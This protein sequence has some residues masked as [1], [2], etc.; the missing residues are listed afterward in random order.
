MRIMRRACHKA[1]RA[2]TRIL[3]ENQGVVNVK[4]DVES[5]RHFAVDEPLEAIFLLDGFLNQHG[6]GL[7]LRGLKELGEVFDCL[8]ALHQTLILL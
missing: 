3:T 2:S 4:D 5:L 6:S 7:L 1:F 8:L